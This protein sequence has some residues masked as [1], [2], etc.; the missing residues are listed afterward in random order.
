V[1]NPVE[2]KTTFPFTVGAAMVP[3]GTH[4]IRPDDTDPGVLELSGTHAS[5][6]FQTNSATPRQTPSK[7]EVVFKRYGDGYV[8]KDI[9][10]EGSSDGAEVIASHGEKRAAKHHASATE[11]RVSATKTAQ[12]ANGR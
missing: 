12:A 2:F 7:S 4:T 10:V 11:H 1:T 3:A 5:V 8:L 9:W 6:L